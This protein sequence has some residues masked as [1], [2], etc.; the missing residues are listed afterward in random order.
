MEKR[1]YESAVFWMAASGVLAVIGG[2]AVGV[3]VSQA[4]GTSD[5]PWR[6][7]WF[8]LGVIVVGSALPS[9]IWALVQFFRQTIERPQPHAVRTGLINRPGG[10]ANVSD[11]K[12]AEGLDR[13]IDNEGV[14]D[15]RRARFGVNDDPDAKK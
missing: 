9:F 10:K 1:L 3:G 4:S 11:A 6:N 2:I 14:V 5:N 15:A 8:T 7:G 12:F 13:G